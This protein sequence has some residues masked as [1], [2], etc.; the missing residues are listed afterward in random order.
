MQKMRVIVR[1]KR[2][3]EKARESGRQIN[4]QRKRERSRE[5]EREREILAFLLIYT[6]V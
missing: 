2:Y 1:D 6:C 3:I 5:R 4:R